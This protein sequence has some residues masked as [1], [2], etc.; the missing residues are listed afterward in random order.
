MIKK[1]EAAEREQPK[2]LEERTEEKVKELPQMDD[3]ANTAS[4]QEEK[5]I[6][7]DDVVQQADV[8]EVI[9]GFEGFD[10]YGN[11]PYQKMCI[12]D[13]RQQQQRII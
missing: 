13:R 7:P 2:D 10:I 4:E 9:V 1:D 6:M 8:K 5:T 12:R 3:L 11:E